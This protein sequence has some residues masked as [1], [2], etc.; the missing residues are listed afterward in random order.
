MI[1]GNRAEEGEKK[2]RSRV[3]GQ[4]GAKKEKMI[5]ERGDYILGKI[6]EKEERKNSKGTRT[7]TGRLKIDFIAS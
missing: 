1:Q 5:S 7:Y 4:R 3:R 2:P 6:K